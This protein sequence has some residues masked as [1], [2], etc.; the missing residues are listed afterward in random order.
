M[1]IMSTELK[2]MP[3]MAAT[4]SVGM[5]YMKNWPRDT[6]MKTVSEMTIQK[7]TPV[8]KSVKPASGYSTIVKRKPLRKHHGI[9]TSVA[10]SQYQNAL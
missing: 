5:A 10:P 2:S 3:M 7:G 6:C 8:T 4:S 1:N 9:S